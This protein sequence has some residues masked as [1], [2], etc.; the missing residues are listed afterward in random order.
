MGHAWDVALFRAVHL[1]WHQAWL[2][3]IMR[4]LSSPGV[5]KIPLLVLLGAAFLLRGRRGRLGILI[6]ALAIACSDQLSSK[7]LKP[8][9]GRTRPSV[10]LADAR[11][12][13]GVRHSRSFPS[14]HAVNFFTAA[15]IVG[16]VF[17]EAR[18]AAYVVAG[19]VA[20]SRVYVGDHW[21]SDVLAGAALGLLL[22]FLWRKALKRLERTLS[23][24]AE[25]AGA[26]SNGAPSLPG[27]GDGSRTAPAGTRYTPG[28][29]RSG[30]EAR[31][32]RSRTRR[33]LPADRGR[34]RRSHGVE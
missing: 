8:I 15:P 4:A 29:S 34:S 16:Y 25:P 30:R 17:P 23:V 21:P 10:E 11:P 5:F 19:A 33:S 31:P 7:V 13:F 14:S 9:V 3:P 6:L 32:P 20:F 2:D 18:V 27:P 22:G 12:L 24:R 1:G 26:A 28:R